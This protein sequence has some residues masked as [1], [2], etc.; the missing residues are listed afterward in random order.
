[1]TFFIRFFFRV[2][3][4]AR[5]SY[6]Q[7]LKSENYLCYCVYIFQLILLPKQLV[8]NHHKCIFRSLKRKHLHY[9]FLLDKTTTKIT[10]LDYLAFYNG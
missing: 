3:F 5:N 8:R 7:K 9:E 4:L 6:R 10:I 2:C 1:M